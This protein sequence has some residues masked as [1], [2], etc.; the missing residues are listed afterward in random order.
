MAA[1][2]YQRD[3]R[4]VSCVA[5]WPVSPIRLSSL[6]MS[7]MSLQGLF[8]GGSR[9]SGAEI[10]DQNGEYEATPHLAAGLRWALSG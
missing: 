5:R 3:P 6:L 8:L 9:T 1:S 4:A 2:M 7:L 10:R